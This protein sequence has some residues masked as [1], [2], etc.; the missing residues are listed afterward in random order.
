MTLRSGHGTGRGVPRIEVSPRDELPPATPAIADRPERDADGRFVRGNT[1]AR[2]QRLRLGP[3]A[4]AG[5]EQD[6]TYVPFSKWG[7]RYAAHRRAE[8]A[9]AHGGSISAGVGALVESAGLQLATSRYLQAKG[10]ETGDPDL[11]KMASTI[12]NDARQNELAAWELAARE[13]KVRAGNDKRDPIA[14]MAERM[15][16]K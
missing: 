10:A 6:P 14:R 15:A 3:A 7:R 13:S 11:L 5:L 4:T 1:V 16:K 2:T 9:K 12:S 8:L